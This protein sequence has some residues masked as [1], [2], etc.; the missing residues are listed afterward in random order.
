[1]S[2]IQP[3]LRTLLAMGASA[4][5]LSA[6][7]HPAFAQAAA[8]AAEPANQVEELVVTAEKREQSLQDV[9][10][11]VTAFTSA[12][13]DVVGITG[14]QDFVNFTPGMNYSGTDR[15]SLR[16][17]GRNTFYVG[18]DPGVASYTDAFYSASSAELFKTPLFT[19]RTEILRGPQGTLYGRNAMGGAINIISKRPAKE[20]SGEVRGIVGNDS[21]YRAEGV[22]SIPLADNLRIKVG[23]THEEADGFI[24]N[25]GTANDGGSIKRNYFEAQAEGELGDKTTFWARYSRT[26]WDDTTG[27]GDRWSNLVTPYDTAL[28]FGPIGQLTTNPQYGYTTA[29]PGASDPYKMNTNRNGYG[30]LRGNHLVTLQVTQDLGFADLKY[31]GGFQQY[32]Y[33]TGGDL[34]NTSRTGSITVNGTP[35]IFVDYTTDFLEKKKYFS[36]ELNL[37]SKGDGPLQW[38]VGLYQYHEVYN[39]RI[40]YGDPQQAQVASPFYI[41]L[42][43][44]SLTPA[45]AN[46][47]RDTVD[48]QAHLVSDAYAVF[49][50]ATYKFSDSWSL[51]GGLRYTKDKKD[52]NEYERLIMFS[53]SSPYGQ[54][55][56][57]LRGLAIDVSSDFDPSKPGVQPNRSMSNSWDAVTGTLNLDWTPDRDT[58]VYG[59]YS[60]GYKSGGFLL[61]TLSP[62]AEAKQEAVNAFELGAKKTIARTLIL[63]GAL[64]Y[65][66][67]K[68]LQLNVQQLNEAKT[69][70][71]NYFVNVDARAYGLELEAI[72]QP[73]RNL[74]FNASYGYLNTKITKGCC[75]FDP[76]DPS[77]LLAGA[78]PQGQTATLNGVPIVYQNVEGSPLYQSPKNKFALNGNYTID[79]DPGSLVLSATYTWTDKTLY[80]PFKNDPAFSVPSYGTADFR[81]IW[82]DA[83]DR[84]SVIGFVKN[85][86]DEK[87]YTSTGSTTPTATF[88]FGAGGIYQNGVSITRGLIQPRTYGMELQYRF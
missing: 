72:W 69:S 24:K 6:V 56:A 86:F 61:G 38:I 20:F 87:G 2:S 42:S 67:Y 35:G 34:D 74:Q 31:I 36:N 48:I 18:N 43:P 85:A 16:G 21:H 71:A 27:V 32:I 23:G 51:T 45:P 11:A 19:E 83:K 80:Q 29:N 76:A 37:T 53:P 55:S 66:D 52:G 62:K 8:P 58:L 47:S 77:A 22:V 26:A 57:L 88:G 15:V 3:R 50:Q 4:V 10:V 30:Q 39:Q 33:Q 17:A 12:K 28:P 78:R 41:S 68:D 81:A 73:I 63:N 25:I 7:S 14:I 75:F 1:M 40:Q 46:P 70:S 5:A 9:P 44:F 60:R 65:N 64:F 84:Y 82:K 13:R 54:A 59:K 79:F 49:G